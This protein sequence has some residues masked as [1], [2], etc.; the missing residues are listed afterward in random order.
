MKIMDSL[1]Q[2]VHETSK[3]KEGER[4]LRKN[5]GGFGAANL[6]TRPGNGIGWGGDS[7]A[8][9]WGSLRIQSRSLLK[10]ERYNL[11][12][13]LIEISRLNSTGE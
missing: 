2:G 11:R 5:R 3:R 13:F 9:S 12:D 6:N 8:K 1:Q 10:L 4:I 7:E